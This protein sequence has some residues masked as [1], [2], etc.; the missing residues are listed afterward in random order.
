V[1]ITRCS[2]LHRVNLLR[3]L[4]QKGDI[5]VRTNV[6]NKFTKGLKPN[7]MYATEMD[8]L[9]TIATTTRTAALVRFPDLAERLALAPSKP[10]PPP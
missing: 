9:R 1:P 7:T 10:A 5:V 8:R 6:I 3:P 2:T 4:Y